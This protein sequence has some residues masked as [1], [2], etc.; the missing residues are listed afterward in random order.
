MFKR[1]RTIYTSFIRPIGKYVG[2]I[3]FCERCDGD[4]QKIVVE[5]DIRVFHNL[6]SHSIGKFEKVLVAGERFIVVQLG[7]DRGI[8]GG[9]DKDEDGLIIYSIYCKIHLSQSSSRR[10]CQCNSDENW[11]KTSQQSLYLRRV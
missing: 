4:G 11:T 8:E 2:D 5:K 6:K 1:A 7:D 9:A 10:Y 3:G